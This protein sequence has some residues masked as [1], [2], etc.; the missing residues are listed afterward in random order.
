MPDLPPLIPE[1]DDPKLDSAACRESRL[2]WEYFGERK[3]GVYVDIGANHPTHRSQTWFLEVQGWHGVL[4]EPNPALS[5]LLREKRVRSQI[6]EVA[7]GGPE[8]TGRADLHLAVGDGQSAIKPDFDI[9]LTGQIL[10]VQMRTLDSILEEAGI[11]EIDFLSVDVEGMEVDVLRGLDL[12]RR[13]AKLILIEDHVFNYEKH[14]YLVGHGYKLVRRTGYN[15]WY[16]PRES[17]ATLF[18][19]SS[20]PE[21]LN[22]VRKMWLSYPLIRLKRRLK[23]RRMK[24]SSNRVPRPN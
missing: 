13:P 22:L 8:Q 19:V 1:P 15:N 17:A 5:R 3:D 9:K 23:K 7:L 10:R 2:V 24:T 18:S 21:I 16:I 6:F 14:N 4:V 20:F 11:R 12:Q